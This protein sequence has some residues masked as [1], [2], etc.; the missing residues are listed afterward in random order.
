MW[1]KLQINMTGGSVE[2]HPLDES[3]QG[4]GGRSMIAAYMMQ[5]VP[6]TCDPL[7]AENHLIVCLG[8][9]AGTS[10]TTAHRP[11]AAG[12]TSRC[13]S[14]AVWCSVPTFIPM[15]PARI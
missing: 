15:K 6:P 14:R 4:L 5:H 12:K 7:G 9:F 2:K 8:I 1:S 10:F 11:N 13:V 3:L